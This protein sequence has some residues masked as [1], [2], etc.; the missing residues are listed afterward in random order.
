MREAGR[1]SVGMWFH[2]DGRGQKEKSHE[3]VTKEEGETYDLTRCRP[4][5]VGGLSY[6]HAR[7]L[8]A[9]SRVRIVEVTSGVPAMR[10]EE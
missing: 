9:M 4:R 1:D 5:R 6:I 10:P 7:Y 2:R 3:W 8:S